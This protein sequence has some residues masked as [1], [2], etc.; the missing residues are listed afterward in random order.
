MALQKKTDDA[1]RT[2]GEVAALVGVPSHVLRFWESKFTQIK[3]HK[4]R[5]GHRYYRPDDIETIMHIR[6]LLYEKGYT[7]KGAQ[8]FLKAQ[9]KGAEAMQHTLFQPEAADGS[10]GSQGAAASG[11]QASAA[12][13]SAEIQAKHIRR[14][15]EELQK[16]K[17]TLGALEP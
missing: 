15:I 13:P 11:Y 5:G 4:R 6:A 9:K 8:K 2:I 3:P 10:S 1:F 12:N 16:I 7:I 17:D 14:C